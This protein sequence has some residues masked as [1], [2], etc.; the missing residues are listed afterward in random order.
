L[1]NRTQRQH[2]VR[3]RKAQQCETTRRRRKTVV[4]HSVSTTEVPG[5]HVVIMGAHVG[6]ISPLA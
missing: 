4:Y 6:T 3:E 2:E 1:K 5:M